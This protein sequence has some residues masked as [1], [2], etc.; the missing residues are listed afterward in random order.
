MRRW[1]LRILMAVGALLVLLIVGVQAVLWT[2]VPKDLVVSKLEQALGLRVSAK[3]VSTGW[4]GHTTL[5]DVSLSLP[6]SSDA[7]LSIPELDVTHTWLPWIAITQ[8]VEIQAA[9]FKEPKLYV[10]QD[11][12]GRWN[13]QDVATLIARAGGSQQGQTQA[14]QQKPTP[15]LPAVTVDKATV[16]VQDNKG[17]TA[18]IEPVVVNGKPD[19]P[20]VYQYDASVPSHMDL[21]GRVAVGG[22]WAHEVEVS[23]QQIDPWL[24]PWIKKIPDPNQLKVK[25]QGQ[26]LGAGAVGGRLLVETLQVGKQSASGPVQVNS[27]G[28]TVTVRP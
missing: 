25:W 17:R 16:I 13:L 24:S 23:L 5:H 6:L 15:R 4:F 21:K 14:Q 12:G 8:N 3:S 19:G 9:D 1:V 28:T 22:N 18:T 2:S 7:F 11:A 20:L 26:M 27:D 10:R